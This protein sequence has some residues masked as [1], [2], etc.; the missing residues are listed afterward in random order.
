[1]MSNSNRTSANH[2]VFQETFLVVKQM[3]VSTGLEAYVL[4][5][6][7]ILNQLGKF[8][9]QCPDKS[10]DSNIIK[11][12]RKFQLKISFLFF[13]FL[14]ST[15]QSAHRQIQIWKDLKRSHSLMI[16]SFLSLISISRYIFL[17]CQEAFNRRLPVCCFGSVRNSLL[18]INS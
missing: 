16:Q 7:R 3:N 6:L 18:L 15:L 1:M 11:N 4:E 2:K 17:T 5:L 14:L 9:L 10:K 12:L 13:F 8:L